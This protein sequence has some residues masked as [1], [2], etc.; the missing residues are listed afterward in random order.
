[1]RQNRIRTRELNITLVVARVL[2]DGY[3]NG[4]RNATSSDLDR[5]RRAAVFIGIL[6]AR[7]GVV[8]GSEFGEEIR[9]GLGASVRSGVW[10]GQSVSSF[11]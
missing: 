10:S 6:V 7:V 2:Q 1:M 3:R 9:L 8:T 5:R 4:N 11:G